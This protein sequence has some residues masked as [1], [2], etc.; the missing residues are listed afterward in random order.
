MHFGKG[1]KLQDE[2]NP[3]GGEDKY[4]SWENFEMMFWAFIILLIILL[5]R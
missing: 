3:T 2:I 5:F 4:F 1:N